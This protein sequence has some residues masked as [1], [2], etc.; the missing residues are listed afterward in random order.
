MASSNTE[1]IEE[2]E[3]K[4]QEVI[5]FDEFPPEVLIK[6]PLQHTWT[7]WYFEPDK[8]KT[9]EEN[10]RKVTNNSLYNHI[11]AAS[12]LQIGCDYSMFKQGIKP[13]WEDEANKCG[14]R[15]LLNLDRKLRNMDLDRFWLDTLLCIIGEAFNGYSDEICG[16]VVN[17]R[18]K[19]DKIGVWTANAKNKDSV[20]EIGRKLRERLKISSKVSICYQIHKDVM[21]KSGSQAK[22]AY[23][24]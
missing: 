19:T 3:K 21:V 11:K 17:I 9:W 22:N 24:V 4:E 10:Q 1:E 14:G 15:W 18:G 5:N 2:V 13:M 20:L 7:L 23:V 8:N 12:E 6:H 16:A